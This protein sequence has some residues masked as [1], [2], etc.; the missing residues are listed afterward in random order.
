MAFSC[1]PSEESP[2]R[3]SYRDR[4]CS[5][6]NYC[7]QAGPPTSPNSSTK[8]GRATYRHSEHPRPEEETR[9]RIRQ[10]RPSSWVSKK[11]RRRRRA[12]RPRFT[13]PHAS[14]L[15]SL[16]RPRVS[17]PRTAACDTSQSPTATSSSQTCS[18]RTVAAR[19]SSASTTTA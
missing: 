10:R 15:T 5:S 16:I 1:A 13:S 3:P 17:I 7:E 8:S 4:P 18:P 6:T 12:R 9:I 11:K 14:A 2:I 19:R